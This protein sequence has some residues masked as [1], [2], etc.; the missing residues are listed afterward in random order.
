MTNG[1]GRG[2]FEVALLL[3]DWAEAINGKL[4]I[5]GGGWSHILMSQ[6]VT[7]A[8][9]VNVSVPWHATNQQ[10]KI[11]ATLQTEDGLVV[12]M[13]GRPIEVEADLEVGR[14]PGATVGMAQNAPMALRL[15]NLPLQPGAYSW[16]FE[17]DGQEY[18]RVMFQANN[19]P[20]YVPPIIPDQE[21][22]GQ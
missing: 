9:A 12:S 14:P 11:R 18:S 1:R 7:M 2:D 10:H 16:K 13:A 22:P 8:I 21:A 19:A 5:M 4:Y 6:P 20:G 15:Q 17:I 3:C